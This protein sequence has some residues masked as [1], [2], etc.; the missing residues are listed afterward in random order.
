MNG[1][2]KHNKG[3]CIDAAGTELQGYMSKNVPMVCYR[4]P[5]KDSIQIIMQASGNA[6]A[7]QSFKELNHVQGFLITPFEQQDNFNAFLIRPDISFVYPSPHTSDISI[8]K[9]LPSGNEACYSNSNVH[10]TKRDEFIDQVKVIQSHLRNGQLQKA[11]LSRVV[12]E[13]RDSSYPLEEIFLSLC[14]LYPEAFVY[15]F[16]LPGIGC[17][18]GASPE[19]FLILDQQGGRIESIAGTQ[20]LNGQ[21]PQEIVWG[22]KELEEQDIVTRFIEQRLNFLGISAYYKEGPMTT[23]AGQLAHLRTLFS[24][25]TQ[26]IEHRIGEFIHQFHPTPSVGGY[27]QQEAYRL[28]TSLEKHKREFY[29]G[30]VGPLRMHGTT[31]LFANIRCMKIRQNDFWLFMGAGITQASVPELEWEETNLKKTTILAALKFNHDNES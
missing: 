31:A 22:R 20:W 2:M 18:M 21:Q 14:H 6:L 7:I 27:P 8:I 13:P 9:N 11:V 29:T 26:Q 12:V 4:L 30:I 10:E 17:W 28:I 19:P 5:N 24:F 15:F 3:T 23:R 16:R 1:K 25:P